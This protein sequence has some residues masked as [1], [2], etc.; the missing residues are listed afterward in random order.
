[1]AVSRGLDAQSLPIE[2]LI[3]G[4]SHTHSGP[5]AVT[6]RLIWELAPA[7][8]IS[9]QE[10]IDLLAGSIASCVVQA[11]K[12][13]EPA[14]LGIDYSEVYNIT[15]NRRANISPYVKED[16]IDPQLSVIRIDSAQNGKSLATIWN[17]AI[18]GT[19]YFDHNML[20]SSDI[21]GVANILIEE[22]IGVIYH[23]F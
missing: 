11:Q 9:K 4:A 2:N 22:K 5:G 23:S 3:T 16:S 14:L 8:D 10:L 12:S 20:I 6:S 15:M 18:H 21:M 1:M 7:T 19:C 13:L 17:Y